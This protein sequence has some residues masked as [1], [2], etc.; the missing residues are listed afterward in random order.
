T[1]S[2]TSSTEPGRSSRSRPKRTFAVLG[3]AK[4]TV[5]FTAAIGCP[6]IA[7]AMASLATRLLNIIVCPPFVRFRLH[8][9]SRPN[10]PFHRFRSIRHTFEKLAVVFSLSGIT[11]IPNNT[12]GGL[13]PGKW[14]TDSSSQILRSH[15]HCH[16]HC[17]G[18]VP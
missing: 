14:L 1:T 10:K 16:C 4:A 9:V 15:Y 12:A 8:H 2:T 11:A 5:T 7:T 17:P 18:A 13:I 3:G 6:A